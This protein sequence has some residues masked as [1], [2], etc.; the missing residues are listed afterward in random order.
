MAPIQVWKWKECDMT[1]GQVWWLILGICALHLSHLKCTHTHTHSK[2]TH[3]P[4]AV[5]I[6]FCF[7]CGIRGAVGGSVPCSRAPQSWYW[8]WR[9][10]CTFTPPG[11]NPCRTWDSN[12]QPGYESDSLTIRPR[13][14]LFNCR[15]PKWCNAK[16]LQSCFNEETNAS[17]SLMTW[18]WVHF[19]Q[20]FKNCFFI[21][22]KKVLHIM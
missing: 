7:C 19:Q 11:N 2:H 5:G 12:L 9:K 17:T 15:G 6:L 16:F 8:G 20:I 21:V 3:I 22:I 10:H 1:C 14:P 4:G 18:G 13:L